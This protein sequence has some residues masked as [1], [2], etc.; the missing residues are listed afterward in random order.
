MSGIL[1]GE[2]PSCDWTWHGTGQGPQSLPRGNRSRNRLRF[3]FSA[4]FSCF[5]CPLFPRPKPVKFV[6]DMR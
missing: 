5:S 1:E 3:F 4:V 6:Y 2:S